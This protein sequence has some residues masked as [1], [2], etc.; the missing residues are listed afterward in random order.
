MKNIKKNPQFTYS[1][2][3]SFN[4]SLS[5]YSKVFSLK[6]HTREQAFFYLPHHCTICGR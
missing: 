1:V 6:F 3:N 5:S 4:S 2:P